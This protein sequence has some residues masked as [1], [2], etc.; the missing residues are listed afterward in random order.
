MAQVS[1]KYRL[2]FW[3][4]RYFRRGRTYFKRAWGVN[5]HIFI[6]LQHGSSTLMVLPGKVSAQVLLLAG[7]NSNLYVPHLQKLAYRF[8]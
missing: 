2:I 8:L 1:K 6:L 7:Q 3:D 5:I 4:S